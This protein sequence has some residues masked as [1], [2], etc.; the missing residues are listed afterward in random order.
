M[1]ILL[2]LTAVLVTAITLALI[3]AKLR[4]P[5]VI[6]Y[7][8]AGFL[9]NIPVFK[10]FIVAHNGIAQIN[11]LGELGIIFLLFITGLE[12]NLFKLRA[13]KKEETLIALFSTIFSFFL[14]FLLMKLLGFNNITAFIVGAT[15]SVTAEGTNAAV[16]MELNKLKT[17]IGTIILGSGILDDFFEVFFFSIL[18][19][20]VHI[21]IGSAEAMRE[22]QLLPVKIGLFIVLI[23]VIAKIVLP[24]MIKFT[25]KE[26]T[27]LSTLSF[28]IIFFFLIASLSSFF[29]LGPVIGAF[30]AG[31]IVQRMLNDKTKR[32]KIIKEMNDFSYAFI[33]PFFFVKI[34]LNL[35]LNVLFNN[36]P[37]FLL[38]LIVGVIG[39]LFGTLLVKPFTK[40]SVLQLY[41]IGWGMNSRGAMELVIAELARA[42]GLIST[43]IYSVLVLMAIITTFMFPFVI[44]YYVKR[45]PRITEDSPEGA[46]PDKKLL[47]AV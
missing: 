21:S 28:V 31:V 6:G 17:K 23:A 29:G 9:L 30:I 24:F 43:E 8:M 32:K 2:P 42:N 44:K 4:I 38:I 10:S 35:N 15:M 14:G 11:F 45:Y 40:L 1:D 13:S 5:S 26:H 3:C 39:K 22:L 16:L 27:N 34:G 33:I 20:M 47:P 25:K 41:V 18:I 46:S 37:F 7:I 19:G 12:I 36:F